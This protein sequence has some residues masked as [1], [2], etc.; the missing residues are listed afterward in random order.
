MASLDSRLQAGAAVQDLPESA[1]STRA[2]L[3]QQ[4]VEVSGADEEARQ[5]RLVAPFSGWLVDVAHDALPGSVVSRQEPLGRVI[6]PSFWLAEVFVNEDDVKRLQP[7]AEVKAYVKGVAMERLQG[8]VEGVDPV[9]LEQLPT[10]MLADRF[11]GPLLTTDDANALKPR[12]AL[13]R[14][15]VRLEGAPR[16]QQARL[17]SFVVQAE[18][19]SLADSLWRGAMSAL[20]LQASF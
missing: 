18:R 11:G 12:R 7:G 16:M 14:V 4:R 8:Q 1:R 20:V 3:A 10:E 6:D 5:L 15:R 9:P 17:A 2:Q 13:Y 19:I